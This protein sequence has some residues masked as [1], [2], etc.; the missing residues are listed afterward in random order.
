M[1]SGIRLLASLCLAVAWSAA[2][3]QDDVQQ[4]AE[5]LARDALIVDTHIDMPYRVY[6][7]WADVS[8]EVPGNEF[9]A[10]K[11]RAG[12]LDVAF[13]SIYLP[14]ATEASDEATALADRLIDLVEAQVARAPDTFAIATSPAE[15]DQIVASDRIALPL[16]MENGAAIDGSLD[17]LEHFF[18][19]GIRYIT[20]AHSKANHIADSSYDPVPVWQGLSP[21]GVTLVKEMNRLGIMVD[22]SH[23]TDQ[24]V[25]DVLDVASAPVIASHSSA[26]HFTPD[27]ARN[28]PDELIR[29]IAETGGIVMINFGSSFLTAEANQWQQR[30]SAARANVMEQHGLTDDE[31]PVIEAFSAAYREKHPY[32]YAD[33]G[34]VADHIEH[35]IAVAGIDH[36][37]LG[38][39]FDGVGDSLPTGLKDVSTYP[40]LVAELLRRGHSE[41]DIRKILGGNF[42]RVWREVEARAGEI[43]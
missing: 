40:N 12:G 36:V 17:N 6:E 33:V 9:D 37:G 7:T 35:V 23:I 26:R 8:H 15:V 38:S 28:L 30:F 2:P 10:P 13:M 5:R 11:A 42:M 16:G 39:D 20:L 21:F 32:P 24:A 22:V 43:D 41:A 27:F 25:R 34:D 18:E 29:A 3:A 19:R 4:R 1:I 14:A 31:H